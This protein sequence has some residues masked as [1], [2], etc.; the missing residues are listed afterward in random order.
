MKRNPL[1]G[2][3]GL[4]AIATLGITACGSDGPPATAEPGS[5]FCDLSQESRDLGAEIDPTGDSPEDLEEKVN[6]AYEASK[7]A[8]AAAP[9]DFEELAE[10][11]IESQERFIE[12]LEDHDWVFLTALSS[13]EGQEFFNAPRYE[14]LQDERSEYLLEHCEIEE[15]ENTS[16]GDITFSD[17]DEGIRQVFQ[18]LQ[19]NDS[20]SVTDE[21]VDCAVEELSGKITAEDLAAI[22]NQTEVSEDGKLAF[23]LAVI[24]CGIEIPGS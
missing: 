19:L 2:L 21:Q 24:A 9:K 3:S 14:E 12:L 17:G 16:G 7:K 10:E 8:A 20:F 18:L 5:T 6:E 23:G 1:L 15:V 13:D 11:S 22:A 4:L